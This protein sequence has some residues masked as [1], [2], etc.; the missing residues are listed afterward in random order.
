MGQAL[1]ERLGLSFIDTD[2]QVVAAFGGRPI[3][4]IWAKLG[5]PAFRQVEANVVSQAVNEPGHVIALGG[6]A[7]NH[8]AAARA[9]VASSKALRVYLEAPAEVLAKRITDDAQSH[10]D[11]PSLTGRKSAADEVAEVLRHRERVYRAVADAVVDVSKAGI[12]PIV[13]AIVEQY[14]AE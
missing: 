2:S 12:G 5:E 3:K 7:V 6:G 9:A 11:R 14:D 1:A 4:D 8:S 10:A 13:D